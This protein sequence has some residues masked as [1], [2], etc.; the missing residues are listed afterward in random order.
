MNRESFPSIRTIPSGRPY[1]GPV[2][3][4][5]KEKKEALKKDIEQLKPDELILRLEKFRDYLPGSVL[6]I[7]D[8]G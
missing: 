8:A 4:L 6:N 5:W 2:L 7:S 1:E 3:A